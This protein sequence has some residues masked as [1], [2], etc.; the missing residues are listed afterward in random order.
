M[1]PWTASN[2]A[3]LSSTASRSLL[4][5]MSIESVMLITILPPSPP[6][7]NL[8]QSF[9]M[10]WLFAVGDLP[11][12]WSFSFSFSFHYSLEQHIS[13]NEYSESRKARLLQKES[14]RSVIMYCLRPC[15]TQK[16]RINKNMKLNLSPAFNNHSIKQDFP[17]L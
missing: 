10:S 14:V 2:Q 5:L 1:I 13:S 9:P 8:F 4:K 6:A 15:S 12:Y 11:K 3:P 17:L 16:V 7:L